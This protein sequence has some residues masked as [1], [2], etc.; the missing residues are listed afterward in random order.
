MIAVEISPDGV[1]I[2]IDDEA[3]AVSLTEVPADLAQIGIGAGATCTAI[4]DQPAYDFLAEGALSCGEPTWWDFVIG[5]ISIRLV[6]VFKN[7]VTES[8][9]RAARAPEGADEAISADFVDET[10]DVSVGPEVA[11]H[12][13]TDAPWRDPRPV[14]QNLPQYP[15]GDPQHKRERRPNYTA[16]QNWEGWGREKDP[17]KEWWMP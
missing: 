14:F 12:A 9:R 1:V 6:L 10:P 16:I 17:S 11:P 4:N 8:V 15:V 13:N 3:H 7:D 2:D 5:E